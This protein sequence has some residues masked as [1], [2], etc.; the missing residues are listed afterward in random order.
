MHVSSRQGV[1]IQKNER[2]SKKQKW[3]AYQDEMLDGMW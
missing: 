3:T 1:N 2:I